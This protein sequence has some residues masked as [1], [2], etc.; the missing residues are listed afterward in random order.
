MIFSNRNDC[1]IPKSLGVEDYSLAN[2]ICPAR[3]YAVNTLSRELFGLQGTKDDE[4]GLIDIAIAAHSTDQSILE[5]ASSGGVITTLLLY[6]LEKKLVDKVSVT[7]LVCDYSGVHTKTNLTSDRKEI[8]KAQGS[9]YCP[10]DLS[11]LLKELTLFDGKVAIM[12]TPCAIAG[13]RNIQKCV[14]G[15]IK[16]QI[17]LCV[18]NFCGGFKSFRNIERLAAIHNVDYHALKDFRFR[19]GGQPGSLRFVTNDGKS[20]GTP[21]PKYVGLTGYSKM[22]RCH[23]CVDATGELAEIACGDAWIPRFEKDRNPWSMVICRTE[24]AS[25]LIRKMCSDG[26]LVSEHVSKDEIKRSQKFNLISKKSRQSARMKFYSLLG[27]RLPDLYSQGYSKQNSSMQTEA[28]VYFKH[29]LTLWA[30]KLGLY[31]VLYGRKKLMK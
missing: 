8:L 30:E 26:V 12:A 25:K 3:G 21:Y 6:L 2:R 7:Q 10:V 23:F 11:G 1:Y 15:F 17:V 14:P 13:I 31:M 20:V 9:K 24:S 5:N 4:L 19:G 29:K 22:L 16:S 27:Y 18:A 28:I